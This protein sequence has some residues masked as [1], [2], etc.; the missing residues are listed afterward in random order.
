MQPAKDQPSVYRIKG[1]GIFRSG[2]EIAHGNAWW[3]HLYFTLRTDQTGMKSAAWE[4][5]SHARKMG[6]SASPAKFQPTE[7]GVVGDMF[8]I[9]QQTIDP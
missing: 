4:S 9:G 8:H 7:G 6:T 3:F 2:H 1:R 5:G